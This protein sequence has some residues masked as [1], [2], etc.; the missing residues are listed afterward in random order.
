MINWF[1]IYRNARSRVNVIF[2]ISIQL[3]LTVYY[4]LKPGPP[5]QALKCLET[6]I[7]VL[8]R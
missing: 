6:D 8:P 4:D 7:E 3:I 1:R 2:R 5:R